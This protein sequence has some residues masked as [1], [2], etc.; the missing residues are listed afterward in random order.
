[1]NGQYKKGN[2]KTVMIAGVPAYVSRSLP[3]RVFKAAFSRSSNQ[4]KKRYHAI[5]L[6]GKID[7]VNDADGLRA[8]TKPL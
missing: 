2:R 3:Q 4:F 6:R 8:Y 5:E 7:T 1:M